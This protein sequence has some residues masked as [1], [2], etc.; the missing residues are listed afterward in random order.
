MIENTPIPQHPESRPRQ[1]KPL[2]LAVDNCFI[3]LADD[4]I[5][6]G[7]NEP[8]PDE[9]AQLDLV[10]WGALNWGDLDEHR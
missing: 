8:T 6:D 5:L 3:S 7:E 10:D 1:G 2:R 9:L 4:W